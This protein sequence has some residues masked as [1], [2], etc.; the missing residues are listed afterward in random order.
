MRTSAKIICDC[1][2]PL[3]MD[4]GWYDK[5]SHCRG[6]QM[7]KVV[8]IKNDEYDIYIGRGSKWGNP[9]KIGR[10]GDREEVIKK[11][12]LWVMKQPELM[13]SLN[14][15]DGER[16]GCYCAPKAC[17]GD[18]LVFLINNKRILWA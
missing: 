8:N 1:G 11:Y 12:H 6:E 7:T 5:C 14:E 13:S 2:R 16:L 9:F 4:E 3:G 17:H 15:L 10:D 18:V